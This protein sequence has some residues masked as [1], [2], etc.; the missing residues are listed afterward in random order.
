MRVAEAEASDAARKFRAAYAESAA[1]IASGKLSLEWTSVKVVADD[2]VKGMGTA[3]R[4]QLMIARLADVM[5]TIKSRLDLVSAY[6]VPGED[7]TDFLAGQAADNRKV[8][9]LTNA[10]NTTDVLLVHSGYS[11]YRRR[12]LEAGIDLFELKLRAGRDPGSKELS[13]LGLSGASLHAKT[14]AIDGERVFVGS[15]N[16]DPRSAMLNC[17]MGYLIESAT[18][19]E[20]VHRS[21]DEQ[22][23]TVSYRPALTPENK[24]I[25][26]ETLPDGQTVTYQE[27]PAASWFEQIALVFIGMLPIEGLL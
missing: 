4:D 16:F 24:L 12:L 3:R 18:M 25:W 22:L 7:G 26:H 11:K 9:I 21:F 2:P 20:K 6:F 15:F 13:E 10:L 17:E 8:R 23:A 27:E 14:F 19:A 5:G 1:Q